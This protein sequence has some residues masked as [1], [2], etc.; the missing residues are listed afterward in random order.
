MNEGCECHV[1]VSYEVDFFS[2]NLSKDGAGFHDFKVALFLSAIFSS[3]KYSD[4]V[5]IEQVK[6][7]ILTWTVG[8]QQRWNLDDETLK[9]LYMTLGYFLV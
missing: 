1:C 6:S 7:E 8:L 4:K 9:W 2:N 5:C 3:D